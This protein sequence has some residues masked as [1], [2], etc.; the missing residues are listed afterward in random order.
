[1]VDAQA[2]PSLL[3]AS[4]FFLNLH[5]QTSNIAT[6]A[7]DS[8]SRRAVEALDQLRGTA[9]FIANYKM[10]CLMHTRIVILVSSTYK[11]LRNTMHVHALQV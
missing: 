6:A 7:D 2:I 11:P 4:F 10:R 9:S 1:M 3:T 8:H 5:V